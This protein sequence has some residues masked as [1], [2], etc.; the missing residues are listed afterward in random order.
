MRESDPLNQTC[1]IPSWTPSQTKAGSKW[2][3]SLAIKSHPP[4]VEGVTSQNALREPKTVQVYKVGLGLS[5]SE[6]RG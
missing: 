3:L 5:P 4:T 2:T 6:E 1:L